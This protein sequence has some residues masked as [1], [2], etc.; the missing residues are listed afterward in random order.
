MSGLTPPEQPREEI[1]CLDAVT[2]VY[3]FLDGELQGASKE[4]V[5][6]HFEACQRCYPH[7]RLEEAFREAIRRACTGEK[8]P[9]DLRE[10]VLSLLRD[11]AEG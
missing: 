7:L 1:S 11:A 8:A 3:E 9:E 6:A 2:V 5:R 10:N 4:H